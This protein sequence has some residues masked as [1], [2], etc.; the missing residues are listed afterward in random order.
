MTQS[1]HTAQKFSLAAGK[2]ETRVVK[3]DV[4]VLA[5]EY[6][7]ITVRAVEAEQRA[8]LP[9]C[10]YGK[11]NQVLAGQLTFLAVLETGDVLMSH[12]KV[13]ECQRPEQEKHPAA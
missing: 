7:G 1:L 11:V 12:Y 6:E 10:R 9:V 2:Q 13:K 8:F 3:K 5:K 4:T